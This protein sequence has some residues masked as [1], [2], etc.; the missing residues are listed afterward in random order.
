MAPFGDRPSRRPGPR[1]RGRVA[2]PPQAVGR[3]SI[4]KADYV[5]MKGEVL[6]VVPHIPSDGVDYL[7]SRHVGAA[8]LTYG[9]FVEVALDTPLTGGTDDLSITYF[10]PATAVGTFELHED[11]V[12]ENSFL[13]CETRSLDSDGLCTWALWPRSPL[14]HFK[15]FSDDRGE[16]CLAWVQRS[17]VC[18]EEVPRPNDRLAELTRFIGSRSSLRVAFVPVGTLIDDVGLWGL[19]AL[20]AEVNILSIAKDEAGAMTIRLSGPNSRQVFILALE[21]GKWRRK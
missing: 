1:R 14:G 3:L 7:A 19:D 20:N 6:D 11:P 17:C 2:P 15:L 9:R 18:S 8:G 21:G 10:G 4:L 13:C 12:I 16:N 5:D